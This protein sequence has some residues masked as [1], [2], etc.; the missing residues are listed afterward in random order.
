LLLELIIIIIVEIEGVGAFFVYLLLLLLCAP[1]IVTIFKKW[2][3]ITFSLL[4]PKNK[5]NNLRF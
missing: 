1:R 2:V 4:F 3:Y 5:K